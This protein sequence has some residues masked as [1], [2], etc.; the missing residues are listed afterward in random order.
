M[1]KEK[2]ETSS[3]NDSHKAEAVKEA[4]QR[5]FDTLNQLIE[6]V[7]EKFLCEKASF[8]LTNYLISMF[9]IQNILILASFT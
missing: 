6:V 1:I 8:S 9:T 7:D 3:A 5:V 4:H 2:M